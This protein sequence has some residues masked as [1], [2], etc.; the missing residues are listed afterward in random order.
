MVPVAEQ[1]GC[2]E[3]GNAFCANGFKSPL[4]RSTGSVCD[5]YAVQVRPRETP[6]ISALAATY[7]KE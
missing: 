6:E 4:P 1:I 5:G 7:G 3:V 2:T